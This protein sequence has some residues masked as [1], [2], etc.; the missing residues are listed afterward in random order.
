MR[1]T[2]RR[3]PPARLVNKR[4]ERRCPRRAAASVGSCASSPAP[5][6][7]PPPSAVACSRAPPARRSGDRR[8]GRSQGT[9]ALQRHRAL[10]RHRRRG[11]RPRHPSSLVGGAVTTLEDDGAGPVVA[12]VV[13]GAV[14]LVK[15]RRR[16]LAVQPGAALL[17]STSMCLMTLPGGLRRSA[18]S[19]IAPTCIDSEPTSGGRNGRGRSTPARVSGDTP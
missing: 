5:P 14:E 12:E 18:R 2:L 1:P 10:C 19:C 17:V 16:T 9:L 7:Q 15:I 4:T 8:L 13:V 3:R 11:G 6:A